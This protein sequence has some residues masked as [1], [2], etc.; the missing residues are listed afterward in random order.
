MGIDRLL[1]IGKGSR[2]SCSSK[3][4]GGLPPPPF[5]TRDTST[6][7]DVD[8]HVHGASLRTR[9]RRGVVL[10]PRCDPEKYARAA[11]D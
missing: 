2:G 5:G 1:E 4:K 8:G 10:D 6:G 11:Y 7:Q 3:F 9:S